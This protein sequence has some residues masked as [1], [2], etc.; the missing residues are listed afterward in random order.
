[1]SSQ[2]SFATHEH[3]LS[4]AEILGVLVADGLVVQADADALLAAQRRKAG[5]AH[6]LAVIAGQKWHSR[7]QPHRL[8]GLE[9]LTEW[10]AG[11]VELDYL[12]IDPLK[13]D[14]AAVTGVMSSA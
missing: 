2:T 6:P 3:R 10:L 9:E 1:M 4:L 14:F 7:Q 12:R 8:L 11:K 13:I 5:E